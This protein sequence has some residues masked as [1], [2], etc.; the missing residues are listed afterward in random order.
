M[1]VAQIQTQRSENGTASLVL[2]PHVHGQVM[3]DKEGG[4]YNRKKTASS[5][6]CGGK[7]TTTWK[8][9]ELDLFVTPYTKIN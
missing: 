5:V 9:I 4:T 1:L 6:N 8:R 3:Y 7:W 2:N